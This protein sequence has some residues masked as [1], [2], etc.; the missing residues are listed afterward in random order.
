[1]S[2]YGSRSS[3]DLEWIERW[4]RKVNDDRI[5]PVIGRFFTSKFVLGFDDT[6][7]LV[8]VRGGKIQ[9]L[10]WAMSKDDLNRLSA[11]LAAE[12]A[13]EPIVIAPPDDGKPSFRPG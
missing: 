9:N 10:H 11:Q 6:E 4:A 3:F 12:L 5:L 2:R 7:Y 8:D 13:R 1:M